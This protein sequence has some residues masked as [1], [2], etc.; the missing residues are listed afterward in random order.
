LKSVRRVDD[1]ANEGGTLELRPCPALAQL[2][3]QAYRY[4]DAYGAAVSKT[5]TSLALH[6]GRSG[7]GER[8]VPR[9]RLAAAGIALACSVLAAVLA[10]GMA[11]LRARGEASGRLTQLAATRRAADAAERELGRIS[12]A[13]MEVAAF[14]RAHL[15]MSMLLAE[16][17]RA[18]PEGSA[19]L[20]IRVDSTS[21]N[22]VALAPRAASVLAP[23]ERVRAI[24]APEIVGPVTREAMGSRELERV[25]I[26]FTLGAPSGPRHAAPESSP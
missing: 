16:L 11:A 18:L 1:R 26:R 19:L 15:S 12:D 9:W 25:T 7:A 23:L 3:E 17:T 5:S 8:G 10:P 20:A 2:G 14:E 22:L 4:A 13:L 6:R 21:G 24:V